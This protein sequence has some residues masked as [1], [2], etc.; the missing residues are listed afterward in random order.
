MTTS[1]AAPDDT[2]R[3]PLPADL[4]GF[5]MFDQVHCP[6]PLSPLTREILLGALTEGFCSALR[7]VGYPLGIVMRVVN[8]YGYIGL[9]PHT[10]PDGTPLSLPAWGDAASA[11]WI[12]G[13]GERWERE[14]LPSEHPE[15]SWARPGLPID[16]RKRNGEMAAATATGR[17][18]VSVTV[19]PAAA[20]ATAAAGAAVAAPAQ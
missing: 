7:E 14:L 20:A 11:C 12:A 10:G 18:H 16:L 19:H 1:I 2:V 15:L 17:P 4:D 5:W 9:L 6:R 3:F 8:T 13:L